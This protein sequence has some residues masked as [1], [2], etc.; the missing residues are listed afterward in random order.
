MNK[1]LQQGLTWS[2]RLLTIALI[3]FL[4]LFAL[5]VFGEYAFPEVLVALFMHLLPNIILLLALLIAWRWRGIG[6]VVFLLLSVVTVFF[7]RTYDPEHIGTFLITT[8]PTL[9]IGLLFLLDA[10]VARRNR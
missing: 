1:P 7:F 5:D 6:G 8:L 4:G 9:V 2:P 3:L 10:F